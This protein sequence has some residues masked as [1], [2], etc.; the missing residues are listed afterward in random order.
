MHAC[1]YS[2]L[3]HQQQGSC[4]SRYILILLCC[5][6]LTASQPD[7]RADVAA[8][9]RQITAIYEVH[10]PG[11]IGKVPGLLEKYVG[12][13]EAL[14]LSVR[15]KYG[16]SEDAHAAPPV[17]RKEVEQKFDIT[18]LG[19]PVRTT[20][21][22]ADLPEAV[23]S[24]HARTLGVSDMRGLF[25]EAGLSE[26]RRRYGAAP[27][28]AKSVHVPSSIS[29]FFSTSAMHAL[30]AGNKAPKTAYA[31]DGFDFDKNAIPSASPT[32]P[33]SPFAVYLAVRLHPAGL[34]FASLQH[35]SLINPSTRAVK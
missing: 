26:F 28:L 16:V 35:G 11:K 3:S 13:E 9:A 29:Q 18:Q 15:E 27:L 2:E 19:E 34:L 14:L 24:L 4:R 10:A 5:R 20:G 25:G 23:A 17:E 7:A 8:I 32:S 6:V 31:R 22:L 21:A 12:A 30:L 33:P 1:N